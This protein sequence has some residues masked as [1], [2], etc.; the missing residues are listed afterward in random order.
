MTRESTHTFRFVTVTLLALA[1][2]GPAAFGQGAL[3]LKANLDLPFDAAGSDERDEEAPEVIFF[4]GGVYEASAVVFCLDE[5]KSMRK[6]SRWDLQKREVTRAV[7]DL[8]ERAELGLVL[9]SREVAAFRE[10]LVTASQGNKAAVVSFMN[11]RQL[12]GGTCVGQGTI[13]SLQLLR[14]SQSEYRAVIVAGD[15]RPTARCG[16]SSGGSR[17]AAFYQR[18]LDQTVSANPGLEVRVHTIFVGTAS[19]TD[20]MNFMRQLAQRHRGT[21]R[22]VTH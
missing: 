15:G 22:A 21:F 5:S 14:P 13:K 10:K 4:Y 17:D 9:Y 2:C 20:A 3:P 7:F 11:S 6:H 8:T 16:G 19:D 12:K 1:A 18:L